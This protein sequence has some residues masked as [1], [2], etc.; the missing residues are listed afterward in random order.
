MPLT[1]RDCVPYNNI[2]AILAVANHKGG[3]GK[4]A[5]AHALGVLLATEHGRRVLMID[6]DPQASLT[7]SCGIPDASGRSLADVL[8]GSVA[9]GDVIRNVADGLAL[10]PA[11]I[12]LANVALALTS[13]LGRERVLARALATVQYDVAILDCAP[14]LGLL[15]INALTAADAVLIPTLCQVVDLRGLRG[16]LDSLAKIRAAVNP[17]LETLGILVTFYDGRLLHHREALAAM[18][19]AG[20][21]VLDICVGRSI[22]VAEASSL[23]ESVVTY[24]PANKRAEEYRALAK[25]VD[26]WL[27][28]GPQ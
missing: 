13:V 8:A 14:S 20:L 17:G 19:R 2:M 5:T 4:T 3:V 28:R 11:D 25:E 6:V 7:G 27:E 24:E 10:V 1:A 9:M 12:A 15:T 16:F 23:G 18:R 26:A 21:P 22:R